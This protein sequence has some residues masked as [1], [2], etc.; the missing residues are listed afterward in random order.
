MSEY[1]FTFTDTKEKQAPEQ[2]QPY[3]FEFSATN[4]EA[5]PEQV[6]M[7]EDPE[8]YWDW[9]SLEG[10]RTFFEA[11]S[12]NV[13]DN[14]AS[15]MVATYHALND[16]N[17]IQDTW[18]TYYD[19]V[20]E[21]YR[22]GQD[23]YAEEF[24]VAST[25]LGVAGAIASP[26]SY[27][28]APAS[29][30]GTVARATA[31]GAIAGAGSAESKEEIL[32]K[33]SEGALW[34]GGTSAGMGFLFKGLSRKNIQKDLDSVDE[35][36]NA[37]FTPI[38]LAADTQRG[39]ESTIQGLY[40]D[41][42]APTYLAK[43]KIR[44]QEDLIM[45]P[46]ERRVVSAKEN[47]HLIGKDVKA[48]TSLLNSNFKESKEQMREG[49]RQVNLRIGDDITDAT[50]AI[51]ANNEVLK[52][53]ARGGYTQFSIDMNQQILKDA[54][55]FREQVLNLSFPV[56]VAG[57]PRQALVNNVKTAKTPQA[58][59]DAIDNLWR[60]AGFEVVKKN[61][62]GQDRYFPMK[63]GSL[64][65][66]VY[67]RILNS[68]RLSA[69]VG[70]KS[71]LLTTIENNLGFLSDKVVKGR[72]KADTLMT[73]RNEL[74]MKANSISDTTLGDADR[75]VLR[76]A[77]D[78][79]DESIITKLPT[80]Q[81]KKAFVADKEAW[82]TYTK[83]KDAVQMKSKAGEFGMFEPADYIDVLRKHSKGSTGKGK[84][85]L[86]AEAEVV[87]ARMTANREG[88]K[89]HAH[90]VMKDVTNQQ[91]ISLSK[92]AK[93]KRTK[94]EQAKKDY[95]KQYKGVTKQYEQSLNKAERGI[96][97][98]RLQTELSE[99]EE[100]IGLLNAQRTQRNPSWFQSIAAVGLL[101]GFV[102]GGVGGVGA[103]AA[104]GTG[105]GAALAS[106]TGQRVVAGQTGLQTAIRNNPQNM[107]QTSQLLG[108]VMAEQAVEPE[109]QQ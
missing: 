18:K 83:F 104:V 33:A 26:A 10:A 3:N 25:A 9:A 101:G 45:N 36:G 23:K 80:E 73:N 91:A 54:A 98:Q 56:N 84:S 92:L 24:P 38:T 108:R 74:A 32:G 27:I 95:S 51:K 76:A 77:V 82:S 21:D 4:V 67:K 43:T 60:D 90:A 106:R 12:L 28:A 35:A 87:N 61:N 59:Y 15:A 6:K 58:Q 11:A 64:S 46:L 102:A 89:E 40:R 47:L 52:E 49:F 65:N 44:N 19:I 69:R 5:L 66:A 72:I 103:A 93:Q 81:A 30:G 1:D 50:Q 68:D 96:E 62:K 7:E 31:E 88:I 48:N 79:I 14:L 22:K 86:Q 20:Q 97:I 105:V 71:S 75:A 100:H 42:V 55:G 94:L 37:V 17:P 8:G 63:L 39:G 70:N 29:L 109:P 16:P 2:A 99:L 13:G 57:K 78:A 53:A 34:A 107:L 41:I 85:L